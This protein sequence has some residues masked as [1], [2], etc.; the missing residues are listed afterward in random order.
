MDIFENLGCKRVKL[1]LFA[2][3]ALFCPVFASTLDM[4]PLN[5][6][7]WG[8]LDSQKKRKNKTTKNKKNPKIPEHEL[9]SYQ[10]KFSVFTLGVQN[11]LFLAT[12]PKKRAP[13]KHYKIGVSA[14]QFL[15]N[16]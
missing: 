3:L 10:S 9:F 4:F 13:K 7:F 15:T 8:G 2:I 1:G 5:G 14:N 6:F 11:F 12:W 16:S